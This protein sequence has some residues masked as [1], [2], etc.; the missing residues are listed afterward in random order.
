LETDLITRQP[1]RPAEAFVLV[2]PNRCEHALSSRLY[3]NYVLSSGDIQHPLTR[4]ELV[5]PELRRLKRVA[6][7]TL[8]KWTVLMLTY[9]HAARIRK[10]RTTRESLVAFFEHEAGNAMDTALTAAEIVAQTTNAHAQELSASDAADIDGSAPCKG[11][12]GSQCDAVATQTRGPEFLRAEVRVEEALDSYEQAV[13]DCA[14]RT[15]SDVASLLRRH[16]TMFKNRQRLLDD[17]FGDR[18]SD[19]QVRMLERYDVRPLGGR[20]QRQSPPLWAIED[21][22][23]SSLRATLP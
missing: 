17:E 20:R 7:A 8:L 21:W 23:T 15:T 14:L 6:G 5:L 9:K 4:R 16:R 18:I 13:R 10:E 2:E 1:L 19:A 11:G 12:G 22:L 3:L